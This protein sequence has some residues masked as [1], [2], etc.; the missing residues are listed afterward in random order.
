MSTPP[1]LLVASR[2]LVCRHENC[3]N[4]VARAGLLPTP[5]RSPVGDA[6][7]GRVKVS[8]GLPKYTSFSVLAASQEVASEA[9]LT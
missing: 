3:Q 7:L 6:L 5:A 8:V 2:T 1:R 9:T 4:H